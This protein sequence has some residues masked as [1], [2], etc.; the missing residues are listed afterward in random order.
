MYNHILRIVGMPSQGDGN[1]SDSSNNGAMILKNGWWDAEARMQETQSMW[2]EAETAFLK[3]VLKLCADTNTL[4]GLRIS[5]LEP[6]FWRQSYED[7]LVKTQSFST[8]RTSGMPAIQAFTFSHLS[9]DPESDAIVYD[10]YQAKLAEELERLNNP[11]EG[12]PL[13]E[14]DTVNPNTTEGV[15]AQAGVDANAEAAE[16]KSKSKDQRGTWAICPVCGKRFLK[17]EANQIYDSLSCSNKA[18]RNNGVGFGR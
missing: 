6:K 8:L 9:K 12:L 15:E 5:D 17:K 4:T 7:L 10:K 11:A 2:R 16:P 14:D 1:S 18:R 3:C 13:D